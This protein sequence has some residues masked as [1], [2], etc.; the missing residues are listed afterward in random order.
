VVALV[1]LE[2][3]AIFLESLSFMQVVV[4]VVLTFQTVVVESVALVVVAVAVQTLP[5]AGLVVLAELTLDNLE[6]HLIIQ[7]ETVHPQAETREQTRVLVVE[8]QDTKLQHLARAV[9]GL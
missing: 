5:L 9:R 4:V 1:A 8:V 2:L 6:L 3:Q 7:L